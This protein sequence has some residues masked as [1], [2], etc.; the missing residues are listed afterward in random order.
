MS[1]TPINDTVFAHQTAKVVLMDQ[2]TAFPG[3]V[4]PKTRRSPRGEGISHVPW[5]LG[6]RLFQALDILLGYLFGASPPGL[7]RKAAQALFVESIDD[8]VDGR[9]G[10]PEDFGDFLA[11][12]SLGRESNHLGSLQD[13]CV[14]SLSSQLRYLLLLLAVK[15]SYKPRRIHRLP[16]QWSRFQSVYRQNP[17]STLENL[18]R[19]A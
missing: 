12:F 11:F 2:N 14:G 9:Y 5:G 8:S 15:A 6:N 13:A 3:Q 19:T 18:C 7:V 17:L 16:L 10:K 1:G 4:F